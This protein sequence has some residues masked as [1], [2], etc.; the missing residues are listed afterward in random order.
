MREWVDPQGNRYYNTRDVRAA[1]AALE[2]SQAAE[3]AAAA[4]READAGAPPVKKVRLTKKT[5]DPVQQNLDQEEDLLGGLGSLEAAF[6][7]AFADAA[8]HPPPR[9]QQTPAATP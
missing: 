5:A 8:A 6:D 1:L 7:V 3:A 9:P 2:A 4:A